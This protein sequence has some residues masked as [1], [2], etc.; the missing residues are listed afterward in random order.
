MT[1]YS[2]PTNVEDIIKL[3]H[4]LLPP[5]EAQVYAVTTHVTAME[6]QE[7]ADEAD[8]RQE[9]NDTLSELLQTRELTRFAGDA[10]QTRWPPIEYRPP[11][12]LSRESREP[13][14]VQA[15]TQMVPTGGTY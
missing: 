6:S 4:A 2:R 12:L 10:D 3:E 14:Y 13:T 1:K 5:K 9:D 7:P 11:N 15:G 8:S